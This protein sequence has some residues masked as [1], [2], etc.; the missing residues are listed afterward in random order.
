MQE[1]IQTAHL[2]PVLDEKLIQLLRFL[3]PEDW[4]RQ[5]IS[6][7]WTIKDIAAHLLD[8]NIRSL[9]MLRDGYFGE[10]PGDVNSYVDLLNFLNGLNADWVKAM[11]RVSPQLLV[12]LL[13]ITGKAYCAHIASLPPFEPAAFSVAWAGEGVSPNWF[14]IAREY[15]EKWHHQQQIRLAVGREKELYQSELYHPYLET[16]MRALPHHYRNLDVEIDTLIKIRVTGEGGGDWWLIRKTDTWEL[17][18]HPDKMPDAAVSIPGE[19]AW[20][21]FT[22]GIAKEEAKLNVKISGQEHLGEHMLSMLAVMA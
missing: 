8:G 13:E 9:S 22:K 1:P 5:T 6:P 14:H 4:E 21:I 2:F 7:K 18:T 12:D 16:S 19:I 10:K 20:R 3:N 15:T 17:V 11:K